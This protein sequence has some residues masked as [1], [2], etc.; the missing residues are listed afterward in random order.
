[1]E[2]RLSGRVTPVIGI[3]FMIGIDLLA[4]KSIRA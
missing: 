3:P 4:P 2:F 1:M